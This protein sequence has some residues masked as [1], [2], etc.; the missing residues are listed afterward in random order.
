[1]EALEK[2]IKAISPER[3]LKREQA[4]QKL[5]LVQNSGYGEYGANLVKKALK[6]WL[7]SGGS[8]QEDIHE[9]LDTLRIRSRDLYM[10]VPLA[11]GA[12]KRYKTNVVGSG[13][14]PKPILDGELLGLSDEQ[15]EELEKQISRE[16]ALWADSCDC[17]SERLSS[18][19]ELQAL[20]YLNWLM[21]GD[22][23]ALLQDKE[24]KGGVY[25]TCVQLIEADRVCNPGNAEDWNGDGKIAAG[26]EVDDTGE[27]VA[28]HICKRHPHSRQGLVWDKDDWVRVPAYGEETG[29]RNI[30]H[31]MTRERIGA[32]RGVPLL[33]PVIE[34][35]KQMGRYTDAELVA[36]VIDAFMAVFIESEEGGEE[37]PF[38]EMDVP[39]EAKV[40]GGDK[41][42]VEMGP[43]LVVDLAPGEKAHVV[44]PGRP[45]SNFE[46]FVTAIAR[47]IGSALGIPYEVLVQHFTASYSAS[48]AALLEAWKA[49]DENRDWL[50]EKFCQPV[51]EAWFAEA[52][53]RGRIAAPGFFR[54][55]LVK[56]AYCKAQW[57]GPTQ[58]QLDPVKE[59]NAANLR[60]KFG[61]SNRAKEAMELTGTDFRD[62]MQTARREMAMMMEAGME[63]ER[64]GKR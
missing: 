16:F 21:S 35:L 39:E 20:C 57:Y 31:V 28:Y 60:C 27:V 64:S 30:L 59:V 40:D 56:K 47:H 49:F 54:D 38:G 25:S 52:V 41:K 46:A 26:V 9:N 37:T 15:V 18:F 50:V 32:R 51:Y 48:R 13:L 7:V 12:L 3:A 10:G 36:A 5:E 62:N 4:R 55:P 34:S 1:M 17:D 2:V 53:A 58:G 14:T 42:S 63:E 11:T 22:V 29:R 44:Q 61:F 23:F 45:N 19:Y 43:G 24:R 33:A 8:A 6:G